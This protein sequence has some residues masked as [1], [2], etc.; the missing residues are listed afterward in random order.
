MGQRL[1]RWMRSRRG[2]STVEYL[3]VLLVVL[4]A[5]IFAV[6]NVLQPAVNNQYNSA[7]GA[8]TNAT[9]RLANS[10]K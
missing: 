1:D 10:L 9:A 5:V 8:I 3:L 7:G 4:M 6:K 2:Q